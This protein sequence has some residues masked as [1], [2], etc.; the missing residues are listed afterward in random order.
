MIGSPPHVDVSHR[1]LPAPTHISFARRFVSG[2]VFPSPHARPSFGLAAVPG[3][4]ET[5]MGI[6]Y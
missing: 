3:G 4:V 2:N 5:E 1:M 6:L